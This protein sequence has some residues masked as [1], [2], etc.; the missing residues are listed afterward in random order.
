MPVQS[1]HFNLTSPLYV[2]KAGSEMA[3]TKHNSNNQKRKDVFFRSG[4]NQALYKM[5]LN[6]SRSGDVA[7]APITDFKGRTMGQNYLQQINE[8]NRDLIFKDVN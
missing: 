1:R 6:E 2:A 7:N 4:K 8:T 3:S 5:T